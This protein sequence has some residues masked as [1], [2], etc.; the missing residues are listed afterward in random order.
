MS[1]KIKLFIARVLYGI[2]SL[3]GFSKHRLIN[4]NGIFYKVDLSE[5]IDLSIFLFGS[6]QSHVWKLSKLER[7]PKVIFDI[8]AN[9]GSIA[10]PFA[11]QFTNSIVHAFEPTYYAFEKLN[12]NL[13]LNPDL[14][15]RIVPVQ[16]FLSDENK[17]INDNAVYSSWKVDGSKQDHPIHGGILQKA[18][19]KQI[20][21][22]SYV[23]EENIQTVDL[24]KIDVDGFELDILRGANH[25]IDRF[26][27]T[28]VFEFMGHTGDSTKSEFKKYFELF[29]KKKYK[30]FDSKTKVLLTLDNIE[31]NVPKYGGIDILCLPESF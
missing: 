23:K 14:K 6:F 5:G 20:T 27:P 26:R 22:D 25:V 13:N 15:K 12:E 28:I 16:V 2:I 4:R 8:G 11:K 19:N 29:E 18:T 24:M 7:E 10:L 1:T 17:E 31:R 3:L 9:I 21:L 30:L